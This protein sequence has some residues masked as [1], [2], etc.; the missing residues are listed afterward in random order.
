MRSILEARVSSCTGDVCRQFLG[1]F[2][3]AALLPRLS[4]VCSR[5]CTPVYNRHCFYVLNV[6]EQ[7]LNK[8][9]KCKDASLRF[10]LSI[11][12][13]LHK[14]EWVRK[15]ERREGKGQ[16][17][18]LEVSRQLL[19]R[20][21]LHAPHGSTQSKLCI[22]AQT[23]DLAA[24]SVFTVWCETLRRIVTAEL[25]IWVSAVGGETAQALRSTLLLQRTQVQFPHPTHIHN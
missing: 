5:I 10:K 7:V 2:W 15:G 6:Y 18:R 16:A 24:F 1:C 12:E 3:A 4:C 21:K 11:S 22:S 14:G 8:S 9:V 23:C 19:R 25:F 17:V 13:S 20:D